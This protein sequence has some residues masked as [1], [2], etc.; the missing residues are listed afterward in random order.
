MSMQI[1]KTNNTPAFGCNICLQAKAIA[2]KAHPENTEEVVQRGLDK[3]FK[4]VEE[5]EK[6][7]LL[8][9]GLQKLFGKY[10]KRPK[11]THEEK[12]NLFLDNVKKAF[13]IE[14]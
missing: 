14:K 5:E 10:K 8:I 6:D 9:A 1:Q 13:G 2:K 12:A 4:A 11:L 3:F 7:D